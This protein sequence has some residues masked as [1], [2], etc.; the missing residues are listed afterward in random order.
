MADT[1]NSRTAREDESHGVPGPDDL[2]IAA[3]AAELEGKRSVFV[4]I[5]LPN[6]AAMLASRTVS[7]ELEL[8]YEAGVVG[9]QPV[10]LPD[11]IAEPGVVSGASAAMGMHE[12]F[13]WYLQAGRIE[14]GMLGAAQ[15]DRWGNVN[16]S[17]IGSYASPTVRLGGSGG[18]CEI[19]LHAQSTIIVMVQSQ[20]TFVEHIDF[21]TSPGHRHPTGST[22]PTWA[23]GGPAV[24]ITQLS[25][26]RFGSDGE[27]E[28]A[29]LQPGVTHADVDN[30][31]GWPIRHREP[32]PVLTPPTT[33]TLRI[34]REVQASGWDSAELTERVQH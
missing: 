17:V 34:I 30:S 3:A 28:L 18:G 4:G 29:A 24:V 11:S 2:M 5:G 23:G 19:A 27:M 22:R 26:Y 6:L 32:L 31:S 14:I 15:I 9:S 21:V 13:A 8:I 20:R 10:H 25:V 33:E 16:T 12:L 1:D 7:P